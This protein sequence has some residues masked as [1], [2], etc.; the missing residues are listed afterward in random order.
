MTEQSANLAFE[1]LHP[2]IQKWCHRQGW[3]SLRSIQSDS[4]EPVFAA[5]RDVIISASTSAGKT[6]AAFLPACS[7]LLE[8]DLSG[9]GILYISPLKAL[10]NDQERRL[11]ELGESVG[12][13]VTPWHGDVPARKKNKYKKN[14]DGILLIT[15]ESLESFLLNHAGRTVQS[16]KN[17]SYFVIDEFHAFV[18]T[19]RGQQLLSLMAR[20]EFLIER[21][22]PRIALSA[23]LG[24]MGQV[25]KLSLIHI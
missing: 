23:T 16:L 7:K 18:G 10:I 13:D 22:V 25:E 19:V 20:L 1:K 5:D 24:D 3:A 14:P 4:V 12:I 6:E 2:R 17:V 21:K 8:S 9:V 15:P 11:L